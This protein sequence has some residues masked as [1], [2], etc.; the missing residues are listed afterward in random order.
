MERVK[1]KKMGSIGFHGLSGHRGEGVLRFC[2]LLR[3][4]DLD[5][6][7]CEDDLFVYFVE[8]EAE[9]IHGN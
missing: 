2:F 8:R 3:G 9:Y 6:I 4:K 5:E 1:I 7:G